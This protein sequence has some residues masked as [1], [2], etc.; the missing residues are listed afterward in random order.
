[1]REYMVVYACPRGDVGDA[2]GVACVHVTRQLFLV[3]SAFFLRD[4][5]RRPLLNMRLCG[6]G[7]GGWGSR[8]R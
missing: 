7:G 3:R 4:T 1:M 6:W 2:C 8:I 5:K